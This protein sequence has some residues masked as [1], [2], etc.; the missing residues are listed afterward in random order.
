MDG[1]PSAQAR[2]L[3]TLGN[4]G[5]FWGGAIFENVVSL[6]GAQ[7]NSPKRVVWG[8]LGVSGL[9]IYIYIYMFVY[10]IIYLYIYIYIH[11]YFPYIYIYIYFPP[12]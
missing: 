5:R 8:G 3:V 6:K 10:I 11:I 7:K 1:H 4:S 12:Y 2:A 9:Y